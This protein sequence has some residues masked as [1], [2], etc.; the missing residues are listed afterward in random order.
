MTSVTPTAIVTGGNSG[1]G[2]AIARCLAE[3][4][5]NL[6]L[7]GRR[8]EENTRVAD[9][10]ARASGVGVVAVKADVTREED[11]LRIVGTA[12]ER[13]GRLDLLVNNAGIGIHGRIVDTDTETFERTMRTNVFSAYWCSREAYRLIMENGPSPETG[14]RGAIVNISSVLGVDAWERTG[15]Y[16]ASK[17]AMNGLTRAM[18]E[19]GVRDLIRVAAVCPAMVATPMTGVSGPGYIAP[20]DIAKTVAYLLDLSPAAWPR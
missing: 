17:Q 11:C 1:I 14:L 7:A 16:A 2:E 3:R 19:E 15:M 6:V 4:G 13:F 9:E 10:V 8:T 5:M 18:A 12:E 20:E